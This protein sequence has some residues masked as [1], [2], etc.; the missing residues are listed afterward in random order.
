ML[1]DPRHETS[2]ATRGVSQRVTERLFG[3]SRVVRTDRD[4]EHIDIV[5]V[6][7]CPPG[8]PPKDPSHH[9]AMGAGADDKGAINLAVHAGKGGP[10]RRAQASL[11]GPVGFH[12]EHPPV[13]REQVAAF[14]CEPFARSRFVED[15]SERRRPAAVDDSA[16]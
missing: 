5:G 11:A 16:W 6:D 1:V 9:D 10:G 7:L 15:E 13:D 4:F 14:Q 3:S 8:D 12:L 2:E